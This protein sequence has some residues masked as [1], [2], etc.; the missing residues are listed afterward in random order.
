MRQ[1]H[2]SAEALE[3]Y[4]PAEEQFNRRRRSLGLVAGP[5]LCLLVLFAPL[6]LPVPAHRLAAVMLLMIVF[7]MTEGAA[8]G[9]HGA[10]RPDA[11]GAPWRGARRNRLRAVRGS[12]HLP[13]HR[14][15]HPRRSDVCASARS[16]AGV[17]GAR[18]AVDRAERLPAHGG[19]RG[20]DVRHLDVD[21]QH[22]DDGDA[23]PARPRRPRRNRA[24][25]EARSRRSR[26]TRWP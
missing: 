5:A 23:V 10:P 3:S 13:L 25:P 9:R 24:R 15:L 1:A 18:I 19:L 6:P 26:D 22:R 16:P 11:R 7:W 17:Y 8:A 2:E 20:G 21:E 14:Q 4:S 12:D